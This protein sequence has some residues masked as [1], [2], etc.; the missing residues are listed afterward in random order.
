V[1]RKATRCSLAFMASETMFIASKTM[2]P[3]SPAIE[4]IDDMTTLP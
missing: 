2:R 4:G 3:V 1:N